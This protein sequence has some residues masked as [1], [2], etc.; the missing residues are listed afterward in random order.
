[1]RNKL[2]HFLMLANRLNGLERM[3]QIALATP[4]D[5]ASF[6]NE[7]RAGVLR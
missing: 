7:D 3:R 1:M 4:T 5:D 6:E 2:S